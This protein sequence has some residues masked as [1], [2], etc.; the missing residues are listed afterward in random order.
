MLKK[1]ERMW[2]RASVAQWLEFFDGV[3]ASQGF[4]AASFY[5]IQSIL[6]GSKTFHV[7]SI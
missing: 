1:K 5:I 7:I 3:R 6:D 2:A 4:F